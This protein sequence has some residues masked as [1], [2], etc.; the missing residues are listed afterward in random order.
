LQEPKAAKSAKFS[1]AGASISQIS[2]M[3]CWRSIYQPNQPNIHL[4]DPIAAKSDKY[5]IMQEPLTA[6][7]SQII[8]LEKPILAK[9]AKFS[10]MQEPLKGHSYKNMCEIIT[11][12][13]RLDS[14]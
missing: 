9:S 3:F 7:I 10:M 12:N 1:V 4:Q 5:S 8:L 2:K 14:N 6:K 13:D 11:L